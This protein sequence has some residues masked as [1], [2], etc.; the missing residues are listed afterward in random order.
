[1]K[2]INFKIGGKKGKRKIKMEKGLEKQE[3]K[4][5]REGENGEK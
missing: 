5:I 2:K 3:D 4:R 1:M